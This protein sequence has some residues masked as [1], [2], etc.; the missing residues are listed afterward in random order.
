MKL[1]LFLLFGL[2]ATLDSFSQEL[3]ET[4]YFDKEWKEVTVKKFHTKREIYKQ[5]DNIYVIKDYFKGKYLEMTGYL[6]QLEPDVENGTFTFFDKRGNKIDE[7]I[8]KN[9]EPIEWYSWLGNEKKLVADYNF[10]LDYEN[11][12]QLTETTEKKNVDT[13]NFEVV[14]TMPSFEDKD[15]SYFRVYV[16]KNLKYPKLAF[17]YNQHGIVYVS[18]VVNKDGTL[19][20]FVVTKSIC[21]SLDKEVVR[22]LRNSPIWKPGT[23]KGKPVKVKFS[24]PV[25]FA[26][27]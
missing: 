12:N 21:K 23:Q 4:K 15:A 1:K 17:K 2:F 3:I 10:S 14:E 11:V 26:L 18:F 27:F 6:S 8:Y 20:D 5:A 16:Q 7:I 19:S 24:C 25:V 13:A 9:G 22:V